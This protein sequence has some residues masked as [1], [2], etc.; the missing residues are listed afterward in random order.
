MA[1]GEYNNFMREV[2]FM[3]VETRRLRAIDP[4]LEHKTAFKQ[5]AAT[6]KTMTN[7]EHQAYNAPVP[8]TKK[9]IL[10]SLCD[11]N[12]AIR[13]LILLLLDEGGEKSLQLK[14]K[15]EV[16]DEEMQKMIGELDEE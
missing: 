11:A 12:G 5:A 1:P 6:W 2:N 4:A 10:D 8:P 13:R 15:L 14:E 16:V 9:E 3:N 7:E